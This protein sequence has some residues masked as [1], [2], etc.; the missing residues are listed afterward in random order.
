[1]KTK[2]ISKFVLKFIKE[3]KNSNQLVDDWNSEKNLNALDSFF[4]KKDKDLT[5][6]IEPIF[7]GAHTTQRHLVGGAD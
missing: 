2:N 1:M 3:N 4:K 7:K 6:T 5:Q